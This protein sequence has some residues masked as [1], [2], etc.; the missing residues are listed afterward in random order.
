MLR[1]S[2]S[3]LYSSRSARR[4]HARQERSRAVAKGARSLWDGVRE[5][6]GLAVD[7]VLLLGLPVLYLAASYL[8]IDLPLRWM[9]TAERLSLLG[10]GELLAAL[11]VSLIAI[12]RV[13][14]QA[15]PIQPVTPQFARR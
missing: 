15:P 8:V 1:P 4:A 3:L 6:L 14:Q 11:V 10:A 9:F 7:A 13:L 12:A 2:D 5:L